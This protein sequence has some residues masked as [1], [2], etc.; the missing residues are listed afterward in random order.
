M[1]RK[2]REIPKI[3]RVSSIAVSIVKYWKF[4]EKWIGLKYKLAV[5]GSSGAIFSPS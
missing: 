2:N 5:A 1:E 3:L 4:G